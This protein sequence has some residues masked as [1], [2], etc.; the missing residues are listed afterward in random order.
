[1]RSSR[2]SSLLAVLLLACAGPLLAIGNSVVLAPATAARLLEAKP[3]QRI[4]VGAVPRNAGAQAPA[5]FKRIEVYAADARIVVMGDAGPVEVPRST[6]LHY[7][8]V[9]GPRVALSL[10]PD[11]GAGEGLLIADDG[12]NYVL[13]VRPQ[14][15]SLAL[16]IERRA[17]RSPDGEALD[18]GYAQGNDARAPT[19]QQL[20]SIAVPAGAAPEGTD[21][22]DAASRQAVIAVDTDNELLN[23]KFANNSANATNYIAALFANMN[24]IYERDLDL[25]VV[26][27]TTILRPSTTQDPYPST[28]ATDTGDQLDEFGIWW[29]DNQATVSRAFVLLLS[30]KSNNVNSSAGIAWLVSSGLYCNAKGTPGSSNVFGHYGLNRVFRFNGA[31][32]T[33]D[34]LV[35]SHEIGHNLGAS[36]THCTN[37][38]TGNFDTGT[39]TIDQCYSGEAGSGCFAGPQSCPVPQTINGVANVT[40]TLMSYCHVS[41]VAQCDAA[42]VFAPIQETRLRERIT[43]NY[44]GCITPLGTANQAPTLS[45]P[46]TIAATEDLAVAVSGV[47]FGDADAG[48]NPVTATFS[49]GAGALNAAAGAGI[50]IG[51]TSSARTLRGTIAALN[52]YLQGSNL[53]Y[54]P[55]SN[56][57]GNVALS[58]SVN[59]EGNTGTGGPRITNGGSTFAIAAVN[60]SPVFSAPG[61]IAA[62]EDT[63]VQFNGIGVS[64][65][66]AG[67]ANLSVT[68]A[69]AQGTLMAPAAAGVG[70]S[71]SPGP[72]VV[73]TGTATA[74]SNYL[75]SLNMAYTPVANFSGNVTLNLSANDGGNSGSGGAGVANA[76]STLQVAAVNDAPTLAAPTVIP[77]GLAGSGPISGIVAGD[78]DVGGGAMTQTLSVPEGT[79]AASS[80]GGVTVTGSGTQNLVL[81][82]TLTALNGFHAPTPRVS[83][84]QAGSPSINVPLSIVVNDNGGTGSGGART[85]SAGS[86][87]RTGT[88]FMNGFE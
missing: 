29:R 73:L 14:A 74:L 23:L 79:L 68:L 55:A 51:G 47:S 42:L 11:T 83:Y 57:N 2:L 82:G 76:S 54:Q 10:D 30:G 62:L 19:P 59:D 84:T 61:T 66:D 78:I 70:I 15:G 56:A 60:D 38:A 58:I 43:A 39:N 26:Q 8:S 40:G 53:S 3:G 1:M 85:A 22:V 5:T 9:E 87:L 12:V 28:S 49:V 16:A 4:E 46:G 77:I 88:L 33:I 52:T 50:T 34:T 20:A 27:G 65:V 64:D 48:A 81:T 35:T 75:G 44:P 18:F 37:A 36:H 45:A 13:A 67:A 25:N 86:T 7:I 17:D 69:V 6:N 32:A 63:M 80:Q 21:A 71:G 24:L 41:G 72:S 31:T